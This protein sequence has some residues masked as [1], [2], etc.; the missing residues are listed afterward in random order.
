MAHLVE[1]ESWRITLIALMVILILSNW[2]KLNP[3]SLKEF[4]GYFTV[5][6]KIFEI[7]CSK[8]RMENCGT[9]S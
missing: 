3:I 4:D 8:L 1:I 5:S 6:P 7:F 9:G 2:T